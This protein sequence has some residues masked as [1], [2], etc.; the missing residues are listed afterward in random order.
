MLAQLEFWMN[1]KLLRAL[2]LVD[3]GAIHFDMTC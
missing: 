3:V 1:Q 2:L